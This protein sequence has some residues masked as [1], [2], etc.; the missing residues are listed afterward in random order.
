MHQKTYKYHRWEGKKSFKHFKIEICIL[1]FWLQLFKFQAVRF[2]DIHE[3][4]YDKAGNSDSS[5]F[6]R[7]L[8]EGITS[9]GQYYINLVADYV[10][11]KG[12]GIKYGDTD[13]LYLTCPDKFY[14]KCDEVFDRRELSKEL[15]WTEIVKI[16]MKVIDNFHN[17]VN[18]FFKIKNGTF[19]LK[20]SYEKVLF[21]VCFIGK[22][23]YF[24][25]AHEKIVNFKPKK[26]FTK[27]IN[28]VKQS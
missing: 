2:E 6:L 22:K 1:M 9:A 21:S 13:S 8:A 18:A 17:K 23:K 14:R 20:M 10:I 5:F 16:T 19:Y 28:T 12:F 25:I 7:V 27:A 24:E 3:Y 15:Y 4:F 26:L 11:K